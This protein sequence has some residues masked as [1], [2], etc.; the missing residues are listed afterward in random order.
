VVT[1]TLDEALEL[2]SLPRSLGLW[3]GREVVIGIGRFGPFARYDGKFTS[4]PRGDDPYKITLERAI[5][6]LKEK[7]AA[8]EPLRTWPEQPDLQIKRGKWGPY[9]AFAGTNYK[10]PKGTEIDTLTLEGVRKII[11]ESRK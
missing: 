11:E 2:L 8:S 1:I 10:L 3:D 4:L 9:I 5:E 7:A 6:V